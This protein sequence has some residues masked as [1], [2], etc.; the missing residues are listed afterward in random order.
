MVNPQYLILARLTPALA[1]LSCAAP[2]ARVVE[3]PKP[4]SEAVAVLEPAVPPPGVPVAPERGIRLP[5]MLALPGDADFRSAAPIVPKGGT[6]PGAVISR[7]PT[8]PPPRP[9]PKAAGS[10]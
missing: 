5:D 9:K 10:E 8:D 2:R 6:N 7:P 3:A 4:P 1:L